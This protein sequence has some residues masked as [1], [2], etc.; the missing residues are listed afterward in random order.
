MFAPAWTY[1]YSSMGYASYLVWK[2]GGGF[3]GED[4]SIKKLMEFFNIL[5]N[6][7]NLRNLL[8]FLKILKNL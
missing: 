8:I 1:L 3:A 6:F 5:E 2:D 4:I 7:K